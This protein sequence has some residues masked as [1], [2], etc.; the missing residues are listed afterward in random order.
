MKSSVAIKMPLSGRPS[1]PPTSPKSYVSDAIRRNQRR[2]IL[3]SILNAPGAFLVAMGLFGKL[4]YD[5]ARIHSLLANQTLTNLML[6]VGIPWMLVCI[7]C[8][9]G[10]GIQRQ[11]LL[12]NQP[13]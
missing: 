13:N 11:R 7:S 5:P 6:A 8:F 3:C 12:N 10:L 2:S 9:I 1:R 4:D